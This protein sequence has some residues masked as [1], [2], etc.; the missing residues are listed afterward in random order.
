VQGF[1]IGTIFS[2]GSKRLG[3]KIGIQKT[4]FIERLISP[5][6]STSGILASKAVL[7]FGDTIERT[8]IKYGKGVTDEQFVVNRIAQSTI[9]IYA[10]FV[11]LSR[12]SR[13]IAN[14]EPSAEHEAAI[15]NFFVSEAYERVER[16]LREALNPAFV[17]NTKLMSKI[18]KDLAQ[19]GHTVPQHPLGF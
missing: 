5:Q 12:A 1:D 6:L 8:L 11:V 2:E 18:A 10:M 3:S 15:A 19:Q 9:D 7:D 13:S 17:E 16:N 14:K 4:P